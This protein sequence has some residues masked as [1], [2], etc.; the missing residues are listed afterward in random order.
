MAKAVYVVMADAGDGEYPAFVT[1]SRESSIQFIWKVYTSC[2]E[3]ATKDD[4]IAKTLNEKAM[5]SF[6]ISAGQV[7]MYT[8]RANYEEDCICKVKLPKEE[9]IVC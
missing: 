5:A 1:N 2:R 7:K 9:F 3:D 4:S 8:T 6:P